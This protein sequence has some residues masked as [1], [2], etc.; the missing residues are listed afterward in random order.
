MKEPI[1]LIRE[2]VLFIHGISLARFGGMSG[3]RDEGLL[4]SALARPRNVFSYGRANDLSDIAASYAFGLIKNHAF[5]DGNKRIALLSAGVFSDQ[6]GTSLV[7]EAADAISAVTALAD[8]SIGE[9]EFAAWLR[10]NLR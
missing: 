2:T 10:V 4:D 5:N 6:N 1:W 7:V 3:I 9:G 8:G